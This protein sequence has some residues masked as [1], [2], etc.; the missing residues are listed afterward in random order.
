MNSEQTADESTRY[1]D[2]MGSL[3]QVGFDIN[4]MSPTFETGPQVQPART[5]ASQIYEAEVESS[6]WYDEDIITRLFI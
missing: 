6:D 2:S 3:V 4:Q 1:D 5:T